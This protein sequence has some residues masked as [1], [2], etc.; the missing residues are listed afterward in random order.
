MATSNTNIL[1]FLLLIT[2]LL[3]PAIFIRSA[4]S[5]HNLFIHIL[6]ISIAAFFVTVW[7]IPIIARYTV[8]K[9]MYG[10]D[11]NKKGTPGG[12]VKIPESLGIACGIVY[13]T[14]GAI[15]QFWYASDSQKVS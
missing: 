11:I 5:L 8:K 12:E 10:M 6:W 3:G 2:P 4:P 1:H 14:A 9:G 15:G 13:L 7:L